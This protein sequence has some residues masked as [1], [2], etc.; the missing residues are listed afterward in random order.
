M[1]KTLAAVLRRVSAHVNARVV[2]WRTGSAAS[3]TYV[4]CVL[5]LGVLATFGAAWVAYDDVPQS[6]WVLLL[7]VGLLLLRLMPLVLL[8]GYVLVAAV[9]AAVHAEVAGPR[10]WTGLVTLVVAVSLIVYH[11]SRQ[12]SGLPVALSEPMLAQLRD[13]LQAA[14]TVP[15]LPDGWRA[16]VEMITAHGTGYAGDFLVADRPDARHLELV[17]VDVSGKGSSVGAQALQFSGAL[18]GLIGALP[19][20]DLMQAANSFLLRQFAAESFATA[21]HVLVDLETGTYVITNAGHPPALV[22][23]EEPGGWFVDDA[24]GTVLGIVPEPPLSP[25]WGT[26]APGEALMLYTDGVVET[27]DR[28]LDEG[29]DWLRDVALQAV[30][31]K[32]FH[33]VARRIL[34]RVPRSDDDRAVL[35]LERLPA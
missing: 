7:L 20:A 23:R 14:G 25:S 4:L 10:A 24:A 1:L 2:S 35:V 3:Q 34:R 32:G 17:L 21:V 18:G 19:P 27:R 30:L 28:D 26:L 12:R 6:V 29:V 31:A 5:L 16:Q 11:A 9:S 15:E 33:D 22:W 13:R 8:S